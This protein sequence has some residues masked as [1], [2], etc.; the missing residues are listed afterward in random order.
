MPVHQGRRQCE[1]FCCKHVTH[2]VV[3]MAAAANIC[4]G[5]GMVQEGGNPAP[6]MKQ[7]ATYLF[8]GS[9]GLQQRLQALRRSQPPP[10]KFPAY[11]DDM[12][13]TVAQLW[14][15]GGPTALVLVNHMTMAKSKG[16]AKQV[17]TGQ[18]THF[19]NTKAV[20]TTQ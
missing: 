11:V 8:S 13:D 1:T 9:P 18:L 10:E 4:D 2:I 7:L 3:V 14:P 12:C 20:G 15:V 6:R 17:G 16:H 5:A 19:C